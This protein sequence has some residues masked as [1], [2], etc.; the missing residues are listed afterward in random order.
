[1]TLTLL[2]ALLGTAAVVLTPLILPLRPPR[3]L[4]PVAS[5]DGSQSLIHGPASP[6]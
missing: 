3:R 2:L 5:E 1:M 6:R 4:R